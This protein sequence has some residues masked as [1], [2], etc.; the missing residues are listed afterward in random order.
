MYRSQISKN[1]LQKLDV[2]FGDES[3]E[4]VDFLN[5]LDE[6]IIYTILYFIPM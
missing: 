5:F 3:P 6:I 1:T 2:L 4:F